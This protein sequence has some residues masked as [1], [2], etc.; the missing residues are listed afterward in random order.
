MYEWKGSGAGGNI[1]RFLGNFLYIPCFSLRNA[2]AHLRFSI[3]GS[4][5]MPVVVIGFNK[6]AHRFVIPT[7]AKPRGGIY[8]LANLYAVATI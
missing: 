2:R 8:A 3:P 1:R 4:P 7:K 6:Q 5:Q